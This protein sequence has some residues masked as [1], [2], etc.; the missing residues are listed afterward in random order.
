MHTPTME[1]QIIEFLKKKKKAPKEKQR[2]ASVRDLE[3][4]VRGHTGSSVSRVARLMAEDGDIKKDYFKAVPNLRPLVFYRY[5]ENNK[6][7]SKI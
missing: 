6:L 4:M 3:D 7:L 1:T 5:H 2:W